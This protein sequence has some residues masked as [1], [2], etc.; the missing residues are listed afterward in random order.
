MPSERSERIISHAARRAA[1]SN[2]VVGSSRKTRSGIAD[3]RDAE[4]EPALLPARERL[5]AR[6]A[7]VDET[8]ELDH[9]VDVARMLVVAGEHRVRL[10]DRERWAELR[11]LQHDA[12]ALAERGDGT[13]RVEAEDVHLAAVA[14]AVALEDLDRRRL[15]G[16]VRA[17]QAEDLALPDL[18]AD[19]AQGLL[20]AVRLAQVADG[21]RRH[22]SMICAPAAEAESAGSP[23]AAQ[24]CG[25]QAAVGL[26]PTTTTVS[27]RFATRRS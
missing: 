3:E 16:A 17:E 12:D 5:D 19:A 21:D 27:P 24:R 7:L 22:R 9:L 25:D 11:L 4:V 8:D 23:P 20:L 18:E 15:A 10:R 2:P 13:R 26:V 1:G 14:R 6:I